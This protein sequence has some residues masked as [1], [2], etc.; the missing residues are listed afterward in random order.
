MRQRRL[1]RKETTNPYQLLQT[2]L[3]TLITTNKGSK[4]VSDYFWIC[5]H[6]FVTTELDF[7]ETFSR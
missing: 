7:A 3:S 2:S 4:N 6:C 1:K 5:Q